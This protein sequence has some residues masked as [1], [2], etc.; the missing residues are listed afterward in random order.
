MKNVVN[1]GN[2]ARIAG[3]WKHC[4]GFS[5]TEFTFSIVGAEL[6]VTAIDVTDGELPEIYDVSWNDA[7]LE[8]SFA[9]LW[10]SGRLLK[11]RVSVGPNKD[12]LQA[13]I[14]A[15]WQELWERQ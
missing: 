11:Y 12:R 14:S 7:K 9:A 4:D 8:V 10:S 2:N 13:T 1:L 5:D 3:T 6:S 15:A